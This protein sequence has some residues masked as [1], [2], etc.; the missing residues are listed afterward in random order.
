MKLYPFVIGML[1]AAGLAVVATLYSGGSWWLALLMGIATLVLAQVL[2][3][4][5][6]V[7]MARLSGATAKSALA[8]GGLLAAFSR[9]SGIGKGAANTSSAPEE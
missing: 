8:R 1:V 5:L 2:Y 3:V 9:R 7:A 4:A 6:L